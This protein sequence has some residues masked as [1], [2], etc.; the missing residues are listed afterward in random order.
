MP[1]CNHFD[2]TRAV[3]SDDTA[4]AQTILTQSGPDPVAFMAWLRRHHLAGQFAAALDDSPL[5]STFPQ[6]FLAEAMRRLQR[7]AE[8]NARVL[9]ATREAVALLAGCGI[10]TALLKGVHY[11]ERFCGGLERRF[12]WDVD[13]L[14]PQDDFERALAC[15]LASG[16]T[17]KTASIWNNHLTRRLTHAVALERDDI[18]L[19]LHQQLRNRPAYRIDYDALWSSRQAFTIGRDQFDVPSD[20]YSLLMLLLGIAHDLEAGR[21]KLKQLFD[22]HQ[23]LRTLESPPEPTLDWPAFF[24][25]RERERLDV[26]AANVLALYR[27]LFETGEHLPRLNAALAECGKRGRRLQHYDA[28]TVQ[29][30]VEAPRQSLYNR[31]WYA[32]LYPD[33]ALVYTLWWSLTAPLR[34][35]LGRTR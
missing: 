6:E 28:A 12:L 5:Q 18:E 1:A 14:V 16:Y 33:G 9:I 15:L 2:L 7:Q 24:A 20:D 8:H 21:F 27:V 11:A 26:L 10:P 13:L 3:L 17:T 4:T 34:F 25:A 19:D 35:A 23:M 30:L 31:R 29:R 22:L 32:S